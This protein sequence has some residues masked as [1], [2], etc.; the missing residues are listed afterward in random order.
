MD[1][2]KFKKL[3]PTRLDD[4]RGIVNATNKASIL[5][6]QQNPEDSDT[7][8]L[9]P[10]VRESIS[11]VICYVE[12]GCSDVID[13]I[14]ETSTELVDYILLDIDNKR[15]NSK[16]I[17]NKVM[18]WS[19]KYTIFTYSDLDVWSNSA[20]DY[21]SQIEGALNKKRFLLLGNSYLTPRVLETLLSRG[22]SLSMLKIDCHSFEFNYDRNSKVKFESKNVIV[23]DM[24]SSVYDIVIGCEIKKHLDSQLIDSINAKSIY[25]IGL[26]NFSKNF[27]DIR[28]KEGT[29]FFRLDSRA[30]ISS[31]IIKCMETNYLI[32]KNIGEV[33]IGNI[34]VVSGGIIGVEG[35]IVV[36]NAFNPSVILG[37]ANGCGMFKE[38]DTN[39]L[40]NIETIKLLMHD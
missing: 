12:L 40:N 3:Y 26:N 2:I 34:N 23:E 22:V 35:A 27:I 7:G 16:E 24:P 32:K 5:I 39:D 10:S 15:N 8:I 37:V 30:G 33:K 31:L 21:I 11:N 4:V 38:P 18:S 20:I 17:I 19:D 28:R 36:D 14:L 1:A 13:Y 25:D 9:L 6:I 29:N